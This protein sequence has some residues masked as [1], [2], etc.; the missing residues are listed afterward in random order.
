MILNKKKSTLLVFFL[1]LSAVFFVF[2]KKISAAPRLFL[3]P[4]EGT[5]IKNSEFSVKVKIDT[6]GEEAMSADAIMSF[7]SEKLEV[8]TVVTNN[9]FPGFKYNLSAGTGKISIYTFAE[10]A[11]QSK[12]GSGD[13]ATITF[14]AVAVGTASVSF[15]CESGNTT[16]SAIWDPVANDLI[17]CASCGSGSYTI[18][19]GGNGAE[20]TSTPEPEADNE[21]QTPTS[22]PKPT[23]TPSELPKTGIETPGLLL[24]IGGGI[25][26]LLGIMV[27]I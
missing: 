2:P 9:F 10:Q 7:D 25:M 20:P 3:E 17:D 26:V 19:A 23:S 27:A 11:L 6:D 16:D 18:T 21:E 5:Y 12:T 4:A 22:T 14:K 24:L 15:L 13:L 8:K 1:L